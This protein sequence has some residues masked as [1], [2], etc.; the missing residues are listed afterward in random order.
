MAERLRNVVV[1]PLLRQHDEA[2]RL[3][4]FYL[5]HARERAEI[6]MSKPPKSTGKENFLDATAIQNLFG[7]LKAEAAARGLE[8]VPQREFLDELHRQAGRLITSV[9]A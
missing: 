3:H 4:D 5:D 7:K 1:L 6:E 9:L 2:I 8:G